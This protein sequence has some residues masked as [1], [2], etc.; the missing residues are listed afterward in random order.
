M[1]LSP[2]RVDHFHPG[3]PRPDGQPAWNK[4]RNSSMP[5]KRYQPFEV[6]V[7]KIELPRPYL[8]EQGD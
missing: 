6:E 4:Q 1:H 5:V 7:E 8:A 3:R 2:P